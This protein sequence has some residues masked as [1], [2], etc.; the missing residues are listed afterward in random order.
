[1]AIPTAQ[2]RMLLQRSGNVCAFP[3]CRLL[4]TAPGPPENPVVVLGE[5]ASRPS[6]TASRTPAPRRLA[7]PSPLTPAS[8]A[9]RPVSPVGQEDAGSA[10]ASVSEHAA[11]TGSGH[12][13][14]RLG[15]AACWRE[16]QSGEVSR[17][18]GRLV[19]RRGLVLCTGHETGRV[20]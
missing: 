7:T 11:D 8:A 5:M 4:L 1:V 3:D 13:A 10:D 18:S 2:Q 9:T 14:S 12:N 17:S 16:Q 15:R 19:W 20:R 6:L